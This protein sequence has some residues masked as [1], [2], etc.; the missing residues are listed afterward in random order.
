[1]N[2][3]GTVLATIKAPNTGGWQNWQT[4]TATV[5]LAQGQQTIR[6]LSTS[7]QWN[8]WNINWLELVPPATASSV[9]N[10]QRIAMP[11]VNVNNQS[12]MLY[13][14]PVKDEL[15]I[16]VND[17]YKGNMNVQILSMQGSML[18]NI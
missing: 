16:T 10:A 5:S 13:P 3:N 11:E 6:L 2:A 18:K 8:S 4:V 12:F 14:N 9:V 17:S 15:S 7:P 1:L